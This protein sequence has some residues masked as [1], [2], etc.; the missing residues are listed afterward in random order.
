MEPGGGG[1][2]GVILG[3]GGARARDCRYRETGRRKW[4]EI[5]RGKR[6]REEAGGKARHKGGKKWRKG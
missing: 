4:I 5:Q 1:G 2:G 3:M 6:R